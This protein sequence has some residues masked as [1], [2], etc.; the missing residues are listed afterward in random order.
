[1]R[2]GP[3]RRRTAAAGRL[4]ALAVGVLAHA[5]PA[6]KP[7]H[8][9]GEVHLGRLVRLGHR[10]RPSGA[11]WLDDAGAD[12]VLVR[13]SR[14]AGL[15]SPWPDVNGLAL[16]VPRTDGAPGDVLMSNTGWGRWTRYLL[17]V[18]SSLRSGS[19][20]TLVP[21]RT[22]GGP[23]H[24]GARS[25]GPRSFSLHWAGRSG[26]WQH[27]A[28]LEHDAGPARDAMVS[29]DAVLHV[30]DGVQNYDWWA[31]LRAP[32]YAAARRSRRSRKVEVSDVPEGEPALSR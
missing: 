25:T 26:R 8:P 17:T 32:G 23:V 10:G 18:R 30:P 24:V 16:R 31:R 9:L 22:P 29:F 27:F 11:A 1:M 21:Y 20:T 12:E 28:D 3:D 4:L 7:M 19:F 15:R 14:S 6:A 13:L 5:R 2:P